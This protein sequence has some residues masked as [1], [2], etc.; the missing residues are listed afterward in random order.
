MNDLAPDRTILITGGAGFIGSALCRRLV[1]GG[2]TR[3]INLDKLT[4]AGSLASLADIADAPNYRFVRGDIGD[5]ALVERLLAEEGVDSIMHL[6]AESHVDRSIAG[7][8]VFIDTNIVGTFRLLETAL[9]YWRRLAAEGRRRF[10][11][12]HIS[13]DEVFGDLPS[14]HGCFSEESPYRPSSP[15]AASKAAADHLVRAWHRTYGLP[16]VLSNCSNNYGPYQ[17]PEKLIPFMIARAIRGETLPIYGTGMNIRDWLHVDDHV[18]ALEAIE[19][20]GTPGASYMVGGREERSNI[21]V[22]TSICDLID[23]RLP[24][25]DGASRRCLIRFVEDRYGHDQR[26]AIDPSRIEQ[27][28]GWRAEIGF[29]AGLA[30]TVDWYLASPPA[31]GPLSQ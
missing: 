3:V 25:S 31:A 1:A 9:A 19:R 21:A 2:R 29:E 12:H 18:R 13:T 15:Y 22:V 27:E 7:P 5:S 30:A 23:E 4:Y 14:D 11:F 17:H 28:L 8:A 24:R 16:V 26:Y 20:S 10:R 6:A